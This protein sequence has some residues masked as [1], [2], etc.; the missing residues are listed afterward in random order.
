[1]LSQ[2]RLDAA[3]AAYERGE[4]DLHMAADYAGVSIYQMMAELQKRDVGAP[5]ETEKFIE[6]LK[7]LVETFGGS[8]ALRRTIRELEQYNQ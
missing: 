3:V 7:T 1:M 8:D 5:T 6:G 4:T 2:F